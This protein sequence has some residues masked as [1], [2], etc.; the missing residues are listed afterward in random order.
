M[1][2]LKTSQIAH[3]VTR[4]VHLVLAWEIKSIILIKSEND[5]NVISVGYVS[6]HFYILSKI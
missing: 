3:I 1:K 5:F 6:H 2:R 4:K